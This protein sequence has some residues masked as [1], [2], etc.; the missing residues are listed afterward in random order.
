MGKPFFEKAAKAKKDY[1]AYLTS[2]KG[3]AA[4]E[5]YK[6]AL[7]GLPELKKIA[8]KKA[9]AAAKKEKAKAKKAALK[10]KA[11]AKKAKAKAKKAELLDG[12][13]S[14]AKMA[15]YGLVAAGAFS[16]GFRFSR[17]NDVVVDEDPLYKSIDA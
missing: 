5:S 3:K 7:G 17:V 15:L 10:E 2:A 12:G 11:K 9:T 14:F 13:W 16:L 1:E 4:L 6:K 8:D